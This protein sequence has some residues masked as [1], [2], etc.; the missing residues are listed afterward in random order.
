MGITYSGTYSTGI[1]LSDPATQKPVTITTTGK[2]FDSAADSAALYGTGIAPWT[3]ENF[4]TIEDTSTAR[5]AGIRLDDGGTITNGAS[6]STA[7]LIAGDSY[8]IYVAGTGTVTNFGTIRSVDGEGIH[9]TNSGTITNGASTATGAVITAA[10]DGV[11]VVGTGAV[12][13]FGTIKATGSSIVDRGILLAAGN[14]VNG[15]SGST[16]ALIAGY[17]AG[18]EDLGTGSVTNFG[19]IKATGK[20]SGDTGVLFSTENLTNEGAALISGYSAVSGDNG[21]VTNFSTIVG[22]GTASFGV[23]LGGGGGY[24]ISRVIN[25][26]VGSTSELISGGAYGISL[27]S[28]GTVTNYGTVQAVGSVTGSVFG[29]IHL[30]GGTVINGA[31]SST[32]ASVLG[33]AHGIVVFDG[34]GT[35]TNFGKIAATEVKLGDGIYLQDG[36]IVTNV[37][38]ISGNIGIYITGN[39]NATVTNSGTITGT[40][41]I[42]VSFAGG[43]DR[44]IVDPG[45]VFNGVVNGGNGTNEIDF[46]K[47]GTVDLSPKYVGFSI[48]RLA[49]GGANSL[50]L[51]NA[52]FTD[53]TGAITVV[54]GNAGNTVNAAALAGTVIVVGGAGTDNFTGGAG[55]DIFKF[56]AANL[57]ATD[58]VVG[59]L[60]N[61]QLM[62]TTSGAVI[63]SEVTEVETYALAST[64]ANILTLIAGN[65]TGVTGSKITVIGGNLGNRIDASALSA[66]DLVVL[67]GGTGA[68]TFIFSA[69]GLTASDSVAGGAGSDLLMLTSSGN[70]AIGGVHGIETYQLSSTGANTVTLLAA[71]FTGVTSSKITVNGGSEGNTIRAGGV[72]ATN[73]VVLNGGNGVDVFVFSATSLTV[74]DVVAGGA[75]ADQLVMT[76]SGTIAAAGVRAVEIYQLASAGPNTLTLTSAN[77]VN[78]NG[79]SIQVI[80]GSLGNTVDASMVS[81][82]DQL[83]AIGG[84]GADHFTGG[85]GN[86]IFKFSAANLTAVDTVVGGLGN[87][88]LVMTTSGTVV[89]SG[90][91]G[92]ETYALASTVANTLILAD[93]NFAG[94]AGGKITVSGGSAGNSIDASGLSATDLVALNGGAGNDTFVFSATSLVAGDVVAGGA[95]S[96]TLMLTSSGNIAANGVRAVETYQLASTGANTLALANANFV[97][98]TGGV[99]Q[100]MGGSAGNTVD[101]SAVTGASKLVFIGGAG[102]DI[103]DVGAASTMTGGGGNNQFVFSHVGLNTITDF[104]ASAGNAIVL[105]DSGFNLGADEGLGTATLQHLDSSVFVAN[106]TGTF[107][108]PS[109]RFAYNTTTGNLRYDADGSG[110]LAATGFIATLSDHASLSAGASGNLFFVA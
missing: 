55:N 16:S 99:I 8:G 65:F 80:G 44:L 91:S 43:N 103:V 66:A 107:T 70:L 85:A 35:I 13:N 77:F 108:L 81:A 15:A 31:S 30:A 4:G 3:V 37:G 110:P 51:T 33:Y 19:T 97:N 89:A 46:L 2:I 105:R 59:G 86:D 21:I 72:P 93:G 96:D 67:N 7:A 24:P 39:S 40:G 68:D 53:L 101:A 100:V 62:M 45:A 75:G 32:A 104:A 9:L 98:V 83:V 25:G 29:G 26:A 56:S 94:V 52:D 102:D 12:T 23:A 79:L 5:S 61:D 90:V 22:T 106:S 63:A 87:D 10:L 71:N 78:V 92:V 41:G 42:A 57:A 36:G 17:A 109:Q 48:V 82:P 74:G 1:V 60:G 76:T 84:A 28:G 47:T 64:G 73:L 88:Q 18:V 58:M 34:I 14:V 69:P 27:E 11:Y 38:T 50:T 95:G 49:N 6:T 20:G 54:G